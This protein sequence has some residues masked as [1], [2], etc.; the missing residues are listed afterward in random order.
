MS[1]IVKLLKPH[2]SILIEHQTNSTPGIGL[3]RILNQIR[4]YYGRSVKTVLTDF[5]DT[6][7]VYKYHAELVGIDTDV[8]DD[9]DVIKVGGKIEIGN[10]IGKIPVSG[11]SIYKTL[12]RD[13]MN[14]VDIGDSTFVLNLQIGIENIMNLFDRRELIEQL[15]DIG[16]YLVTKEED[17]RDIIFLNIDAIQKAPIDVL[18]ILSTIMPI[19]G[20]LSEDGTTMTVIKSVFSDFANMKIKLGGEE[21]NGI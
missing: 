17:I 16:E 2:I 19:I 15:H 20:K 14:S 10:I 7:A 3:F 5:L 12:H 4:N 8:I 6:L 1:G 18:A 11:Y 9:V 13:V 21:Q